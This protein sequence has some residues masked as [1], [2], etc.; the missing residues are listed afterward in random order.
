MK[1]III[2]EERLDEL[3]DA[4]VNVLLAQTAPASSTPK[5]PNNSDGRV[6][7]RAVNYHLHEMINKIKGDS[8]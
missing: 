1:V 2:S 3:R 8:L 5:D 7:F 6:S 4:F